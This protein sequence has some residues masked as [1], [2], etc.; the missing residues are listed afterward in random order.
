[1]SKTAITSPSS[2]PPIGPFSQAIEVGGFLY[3]S[4]QVGQD[5]Y[6]QGGRGGN[7]GRDR[8]GSFGI[9]RRFSSG[10]QEFDHVARAG[11][12]LHEHE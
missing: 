4:G 11:V 9:S 6:W 10:R 2:R 3:F 8:S 12:Y 5:S 7:C 1:M